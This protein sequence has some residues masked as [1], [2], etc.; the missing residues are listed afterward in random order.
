[1]ALV[2]AA[3]QILVRCALIELARAQT[4]GL[5]EERLPYG[6]GVEAVAALAR[7]CVPFKGL[8]MIVGADVP[9][10]RATD[11]FF[12]LV[13]GQG[14]SQLRRRSEALRREGVEVLKGFRKLKEA[15]PVSSQ[16][17]GGLRRK[18]YSVES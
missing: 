16:V 6:F 2:E 12:A 9:E 7:H 18:W 1:M 5:F 4:P 8:L 14:A 13:Q 17:Q 11:P 10:A 15:A 3:R